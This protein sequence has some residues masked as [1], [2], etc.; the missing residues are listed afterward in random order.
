M[1]KFLTPAFPIAS[2]LPWIILVVAPLT[3]FMGNRDHYGDFQ[4]LMATLGAVFVAASVLLLAILRL[5]ERVPTLLRSVAGLLVGLAFGAWI[6][7]QLL[8]WDLGPLDGRGIP[9]ESFR[10]H[11]RLEAAV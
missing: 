8:N 3:M 6:Q 7:S 5:A 4:Q 10:H 1:D 11:A 2:A 9:W